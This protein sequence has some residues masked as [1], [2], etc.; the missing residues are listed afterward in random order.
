MIFRR[1]STFTDLNR[2]RE[3]L[4]VLVRHGFGML[5]GQLNLRAYLPWRILKSAPKTT[6]RS[7][8]DAARRSTP[9]RVRLMLEALGPVYIKLGQTLSMRPDILP[10]EYIAELSKLQDGVPPMSKEAVREV[11][12]E[13][14]GTYPENY[15]KH[16]DTT[17]VAAAS[18]AQV[19]HAT[20][21]D[22]REVAIKI[23]R[24]GL[25]KILDAD[26][27]I[28]RFFARLWESVHKQELPRR[29]VEFVD[30]FDRLMREELDFTV[31]GLHV[32]LLRKNF[33]DRPGYHFPYVVWPMT[34]SRC[35]TQEFIVG[36][37]LTELPKKMP[38]EERERL[39][40]TLIDAYTLMA[41]EDHF[42]HADPHP[43]NLLLDPDG[44][45]VFLDSG[46]VGRLDDE[47]VA[48]FTDMLLALVNRDTA[49]VVE[50]YLD[51]GT[52]EDT[53]D[54]RAL[55]RDVTIFLE[56][57]YSLSVEE[58]SFGKSLQDLIAV[59]V[60]H[61]IELPAD[62]VVLAKTFLGAESLARTLNPRLNLVE[63]VRP[64]AERIIRERYEPKQV[65]KTLRR[66]FRGFGKFL[67][68]LPDQVRD[69]LT[70]LQRGKL[71]IAFQHQGLEEFQ[72]HIE[73]ASN[74]F[75]FSVIV[76]AVV[77]GSSLLMV[78]HIAPLW[79]D[80]SIIGFFGYALAGIL[81]IW[82][83]VD[84]LRSGKM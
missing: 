45:L 6:Q 54:L 62:F 1:A 17:P 21:K 32:D 35:L 40:Q 20:T 29:P 82:L 19:H 43:G 12:H 69:L 41:L 9:E 26:I 52:A 64:T 46:Q 33:K 13:E 27:E 53:V 8:P 11:L 23:Q 60:K 18:I 67:F 14:L 81:G 70:K 39:A 7:P 22:G 57:Y 68:N 74:R 77:I 10:P 44:S 56:R 37:K 59:A 55:K 49:G 4:Q 2:L 84:I 50:A 28:L 48:A 15:F 61:K 24:Q 47:T 38:V 66:G 63:A 75:A 3:I 36:R 34:T 71:T 79:G 30:E 51:L 25:K 42:F 78:A 31:E 5:I 58:L 80:F 16:F 65:V 76:A 73:R 72:Q 83:I